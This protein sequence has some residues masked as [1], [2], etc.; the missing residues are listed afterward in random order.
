MPKC[1]LPR[2][3]LD[4]CFCTYIFLAKE[5]LSNSINIVT[6]ANNKDIQAMNLITI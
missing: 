4:G 1:D 3:P 5:T 6:K 2:T